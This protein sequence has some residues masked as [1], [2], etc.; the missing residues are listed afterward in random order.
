MR[1]TFIQAPTKILT[2]TAAISSEHSDKQR[3]RKSLPLFK[4]EAILHSLIKS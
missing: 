1:E 4:Q 3:L 2:L